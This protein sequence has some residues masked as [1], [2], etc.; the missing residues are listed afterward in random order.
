MALKHS[1]P[2]SLLALVV[3]NLSPLIGLLLFGW[4][5]TAIVFLYWLENLVVGVWNILRMKKARGTGARL[6]FT[7][8][9]RPATALDRKTLIKFFVVHYGAFTAG[10]GLFVLLLFGIPQGGFS[11]IL[12]SLGLLFASHGVSYV[13]NFIQ[14]GEYLT[15][16]PHDLFLQPYRRVVV[17]HLVVIFCGFWLQ[18]AGGAAITVVFMVA[19]KLGIDLVAHLFERRKLMARAG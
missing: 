19:I 12:V 9:D 16:S 10:H 2:L 13:K 14:G 1:H 3:A 4:E 8:N 18:M 6:D 5:V 17:L 7:I 15:A 11:W